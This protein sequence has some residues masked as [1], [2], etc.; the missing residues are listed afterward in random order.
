MFD[1][2]EM[3]EYIRLRQESLLPNKVIFTLWPRNPF[4]GENSG[5]TEV[6]KKVC[7]ES[8]ARANVMLSL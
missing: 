8:S 4:C 3:Y 1:Y 2:G 7:C 6:W 5:S